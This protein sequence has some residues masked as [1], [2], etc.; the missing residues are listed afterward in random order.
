MAAPNL[1]NLTSVTGKLVG[2]AMTTSHTAVLTNASSSN[3]L[4][5]INSI[6]VSN[7][8]GT[9]AADA[10]ISIYKNATTDYYVAS[11]ISVPADATLIVATKD[12]NL[13]LEENDSVRASASVNGY[14]QILISYEEVT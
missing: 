3:K 11:T 7:I 12:M 9:A 8:N 6:V 2:A 14:L 10:T 1:L 13:Y 4:F 5:R